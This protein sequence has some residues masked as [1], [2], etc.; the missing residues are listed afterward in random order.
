MSQT[1]MKANVSLL[2]DMRSVCSGGGKI[3]DQ[4][5]NN[6][7]RPKKEMNHLQQIKFIIGSF[8]FCKWCANTNVNVVHT[9]KCGKFN[10]TECSWCVFVWMNATHTFCYGIQFMS[11][12]FLCDRQ[13]VMRRYTRE[14][15]RCGATKKN[16]FFFF[17]FHSVTHFALH[18]AWIGTKQNK[19]SS[20]CCC[21]SHSLWL[22]FIWS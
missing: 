3:G 13:T 2:D 6:D 1:R 18:I 20:F 15:V 14:Y 16:I 8:S 7:K 21:Y 22:I 4:R 9:H 5:I 19:K 17:S 12:S 11:P 10:S